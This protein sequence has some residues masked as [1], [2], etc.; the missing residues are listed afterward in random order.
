[1]DFSRWGM[2]RVE[3]FSSQIEN[4]VTTSL[5]V[6]PGVVFTTAWRHREKVSPFSDSSHIALYHS[7]DFGALFLLLRVCRYCVRTC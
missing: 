3:V 4:Q 1:M 2:S 5:L 7:Y 6:R